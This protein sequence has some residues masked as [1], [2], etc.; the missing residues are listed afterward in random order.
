MPNANS[1]NQLNLMRYYLHCIVDSNTMSQDKLQIQ[2]HNISQA[3]GGNFNVINV[4]WPY[5][6]VY[7]FICLKANMEFA[8]R[9]E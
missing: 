6:D 2:V 5:S 8:N 7:L 9:V 1:I 4:I 3:L